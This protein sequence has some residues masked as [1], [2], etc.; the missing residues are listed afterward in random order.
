[1]QLQNH[2][3]NLQF[4]RIAN[5]WNSYLVDFG[6]FLRILTK[7]VA[8]ANDASD[9]NQVRKSWFKVSAKKLKNHILSIVSCRGCIADS[10]YSWQLKNGRTFTAC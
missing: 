1:M 10:N 8:I 6:I 3:P 7:L 4:H 2:L 5:F 9:C